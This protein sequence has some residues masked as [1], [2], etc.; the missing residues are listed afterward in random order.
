MPNGCVSSSTASQRGSTVVLDSR[1]AAFWMRV[2]YFRGPGRGCLR[3]RSP[4]DKL[5]RPRPPGKRC[6][7]NVAPA[8]M[9]RPIRGFRPRSTLN[10]MPAGRILRALDFGAMMTVAYPMSRDERQA[11]A[12]YIGTNAPAIAFPPALTAPIAGPSSPSRPKSSWNGWSPGS[13]NARY[14]SAEAAGLS[15]DQVRGLKLK[16][17]FGFD[18][19]VTAFSQPTVI[20]GQVFVGSA[21][22]VIHALR[23]DTGCLAVDLPGQRPRALFR[24]F[25]SRWEPAHLAVR[26]SDGLVLFARG[27]DRCAVVE[28]EESRSTTRHA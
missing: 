14:Q 7:N 26:R 24:S 22:G 13:N 19:D 8:A 28:K 1:H 15:I 9:S 18:G 4:W 23:A 6:T 25:G 11:V 27:R 2:E 21:G 12:A 5:R 20:D 10:Q 16:W 3:Q 17:A